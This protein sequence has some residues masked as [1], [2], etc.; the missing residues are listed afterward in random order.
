MWMSNGQ[1]TRRVEFFC[2]AEDMQ[3]QTQ[4]QQSET[5]KDDPTIMVE[6]TIKKSRIDTHCEHTKRHDA[7]CILK[8]GKRNRDR[9][10]NNPGPRLSQIKM[11]RK[12]SASLTFGH[13]GETK[14][15]AARRD[16]E[17]T[18][19]QRAPASDPVG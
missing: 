16:R 18:H 13:S 11:S 1:N 7:N 2:P 6:P 4:N 10:Q 8:N 17:R 5:V 9:D 3:D 14:T 12:R 19:I 15:R